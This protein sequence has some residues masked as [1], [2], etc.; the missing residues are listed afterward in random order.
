MKFSVFKS[1]KAQLGEQCTHDLYLEMSTAKWLME[2]CN[3]IADTDDK[4]RRS[5]LKKQLPVITWQAWFPGRRLIKEAQPSGLFMLD[6]DHVEKPY[7]LYSEKV[8]GR[9]A[10]LGIVYAGMTASRHGLRIVAKC[11]PE[12]KTL[13]ECQKWLADSLGVEYDGVCKDFARCSFMVHDSYTYYMDTK[14]IWTDEPA[15]GTIYSVEDG[16]L[17]MC[18]NKKEPFKVNDEFEQALKEAEEY[19]Q[20]K[21]P[22]TKAKDEEVDQREGL[23]GGNNTYKGIDLTA[24]A[25]EWIEQTGG[26]EEGVRNIRLFKLALRMRYICNFNAATMLR[27]MPN[28]RLP[29]EEMQE[30]IRSALTKQKAADLPTDLQMVIRTLQKQAKFKTEDG[31]IP[32]VITDTSKLPPLPP[33]IK[34]FV[35]IAPEDFKQAVLMCQLPILGT[36]GSRLRAKYLD[37][38]MHSP[39][40]LVSLEAPQASGKSFM[41]KLVDYELGALIEHDNDERE[42]EREYDA[43]VREMKLL[44]IKVTKENKDEVIGSRPDTLIRYVPATMSITKLL[45]RMYAANGLHLF[46]MAEEIDTVTKTFKRGISSYSDLLRVAFDNGT[47]GQ[48]YASENSF[49]GNVKIF[50]NMLTSGTPKAMRRFYPDVEDGLVSRVAFVTLPDQ[51]GKRMPVW[52]ELDKEAKKI[53]DRGLIALNE[54]SIIGNDVQGEHEMKLN[55]LNAELEKW[56]LAQQAEAV[57]ADDRTRDVFCRRAAVIGFRA[58]MLAFFLY[59]EART[60]PIIRNV[61]K[62][63]IYVANCCLNQHL[64]RFNVEGTNSNTNRWE[65][66]YKQLPQVFNRMELEKALRENDFNT[67]T[68]QVLYL[69]KLNNLIETVKEGVTENGVKMGLK[70]KKIN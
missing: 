33:V 34:Q 29:K 16:Q 15:D 43:K 52:G 41:R 17:S 60:P 67:E 14:A 69:W 63:A 68:K 54:I 47:Y 28:Y 53:V 62:L 64:L 61:K 9:H 38:T 13:A 21:K 37:G 7:E 44:N 55:W 58:G 45:M 2:L 6:V 70:Y 27:V 35:D 22:S 42:K 66:V 65:S 49:S 59:N 50:Y 32:E 48:D 26:I 10:E 20:D 57:K 40:F 4:D 24:I 31:E 51:F 3:K 11:R 39:S 25:K 1:A 23:F 12:F 8:A 36:L 18:D 56:L 30:I 19:A 46:A 5:E